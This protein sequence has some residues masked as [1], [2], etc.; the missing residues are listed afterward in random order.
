MRVGPLRKNAFKGAL[1]WMFLLLPV[2]VFGRGQVVLTTLC[3]VESLPSD[4]QNRLKSDFGSWK[5]QEPADLSPRA[6]RRWESEQPLECPGIAVGHFESAKTRSYAILLVP[7]AHSNGGYRFLV[8]NERAGQPTYEA[9]LLDKLDQ[10]GAANY[11]IRRTPISK[12]FDEP[13]RKKFQAHTVDGILLVDSAED[14]YEVEVYFWS[15][16]R[17]RNAPIDY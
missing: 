13:S 16:G 10:N 15:G 1:S 4:I 17:Y 3:K 12:F 11:F 2:L 14:E 5:I 7:V 6:H 9:R 8:F